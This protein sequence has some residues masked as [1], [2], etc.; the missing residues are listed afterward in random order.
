MSCQTASFSLSVIIPINHIT[1]HTCLWFQEKC[2]GSVEDTWK[3]LLWHILCDFSVHVELLSS[4][5]NGAFDESLSEIFLG[6]NS[7]DMHLL[8]IQ[9]YFKWHGLMK[10]MCISSFSCTVHQFLQTFLTYLHGNYITTWCFKCLN[11][12]SAYPLLSWFMHFLTGC[13]NL[14]ELHALFQFNSEK[15][16]IYVRIILFCNRY[17]RKSH[18]VNYILRSLLQ[19]LSVALIVD[20]IEHIILLQM[21]NKNCFKAVITYF[22]FS[23]ANVILLICCKL[24]LILMILH[25]PFLTHR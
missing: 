9:W 7:T 25:C 8:P 11:M 19:F 1:F 14:S 16:S 17:L 3:L 2:M 13:M 18:I 23:P 24:Y 6:F 4:F 22:K 10:G 20:F 12:Q 5:S 15:W 21:E